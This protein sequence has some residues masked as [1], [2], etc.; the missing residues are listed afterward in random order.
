MARRSPPP[1][2]GSSC[3][4]AAAFAAGAPKTESAAPHFWSRTALGVLV[5]IKVRPGARRALL[6]GTLAAARLP[7]WP[8]GRLRVAVTEPAEGGRAN[9]AV[10][11]ALAAALGVTPRDVTIIAG[12]TARDKLVSVRASA[13]AL[14]PLLARLAG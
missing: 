11:A 5:A 6:E 12:R 2:P 8:A 4:G 10:T 7:G 3:P 1:S 9:E 14:A 13:E